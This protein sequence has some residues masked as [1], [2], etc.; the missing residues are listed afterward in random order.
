VEPNTSQLKT[1]EELLQEVQAGQQ[2]LV[3]PTGQ[4]I[5]LAPLEIHENLTIET[6]S[7]GEEL[8]DLGLVTEVAFEVNDRWMQ[9]MLDTDYELKHGD[10][11]HAAIHHEMHQKIQS[12][13]LIRRGDV[14][15][16]NKFSGMD[17]PGTSFIAIHADDVIAKVEGLPVRLKSETDRSDHPLR[18]TPDGRSPTQ[19]LVPPGS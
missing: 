18:N 4:R 10:D 17:V 9:R 2:V 14:L 13:C 7:F 6:V 3:Y 15:C 12:H 1:P 5:I 11:E 16:I 19:V 8:A